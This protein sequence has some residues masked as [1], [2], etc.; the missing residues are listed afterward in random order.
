MESR[1]GPVV[2]SRKSKLKITPGMIV[3]TSQ[4]NPDTRMPDKVRQLALDEHEKRKEIEEMWRAGGRTKAFIPQTPQ[5]RAMKARMKLV[6]SQM[7]KDKTRLDAFVRMWQKPMETDGAVY[8]DA[9]E[10][11]G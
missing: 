5:A 10:I 7:E 11:D 3:Q 9:E 1:A 8:I 4:Y 2:K 6:L